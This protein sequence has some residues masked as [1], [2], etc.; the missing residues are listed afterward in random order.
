MNP[1]T[2]Y[3]NDDYPYTYGDAASPI[4]LILDYSLKRKINSMSM[5]N[6]KF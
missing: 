1:N 5:L 2:N 6:L 4:S 3:P